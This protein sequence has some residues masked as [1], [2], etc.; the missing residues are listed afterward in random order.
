MNP[1]DDTFI[2]ASLDRTVRI[3]DLKSTGCQGLVR[4]SGRMAAAYDPSGLL[5]AVLSATNTISL[6]DKRNFD[7]GPFKTWQLDYPPF[8]WKTV[9]FNYN[10]NQILL[11][12]TS[13]LV[14]LV[15]SFSGELI[16]ELRPHGDPNDHILTVNF[17]PN[18]QYIFVL[19]QNSMLG[20]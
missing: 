12:T 20:K 10:G 13:G 17:T 5:F 11:L 19:Q 1:V 18:A 6:Y 16:H 9:E 3:W 2:S 8:E 15:D 7:L 14:F 4:R